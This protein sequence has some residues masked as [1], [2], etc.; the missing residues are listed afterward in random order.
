MVT[1]SKVEGESEIF[2]TEIQLER[3]N[4]TADVA[5]SVAGF[6]VV[7]EVSEIEGDGRT[8]NVSNLSYLSLPLLGAYIGAST[9][10]GNS[11]ATAT[12]TAQSSSFQGVVIGECGW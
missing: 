6:Y 3:S 11:S 9:T 10:T 12:E 2:F 7:T 4:P 1:L 5:V 8:T